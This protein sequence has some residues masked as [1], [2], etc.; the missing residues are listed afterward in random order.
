MLIPQL[1]VAALLLFEIWLLLGLARDIKFIVSLIVWRLKRS[2]WQVVLWVSVASNTCGWLVTTQTNFKKGVGAFILLVFLCNIP[3]II[4][5]CN[6]LVHVCTGSSDYSC[7]LII[8]ISLWTVRLLLN[9]PL[10]LQ[11]FRNCL[12]CSCRI[13]R[14]RSSK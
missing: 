10:L 7:S 4:I 6:W 5:S 11:L 3:I 14:R 8:E 2:L 12:V 1:S 13:L 9:W